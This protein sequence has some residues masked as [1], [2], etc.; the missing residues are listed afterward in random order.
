MLI[1]II[2]QLI[3]YKFNYFC[4]TSINFEYTFSFNE[5]CKTKMVYTSKQLDKTLYAVSQFHFSQSDRLTA[6]YTNL[7]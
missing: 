5:F 4:I 7:S 2:H 1:I 6:H 3:A